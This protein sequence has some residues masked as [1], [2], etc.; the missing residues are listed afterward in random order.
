MV[1]GEGTLKGSRGGSLKHQESPPKATLKYKKYNGDA[2]PTQLHTK[3]LPSQQVAELAQ[4]ARNVEGWRPRPKIIEFFNITDFSHHVDCKVPVDEPIFQPFPPEVTFHNYEP[5]QIYEATLYLRNNDYGEE[6]SDDEEAIL[7]SGAAQLARRL[8]NAQRDA[9]L[10]EHLF[11]DRNFAVSPADGTIWPRSEVEVVVT[12]SP[13]YAREYEVVAYVDLAG[14]SER[15]PVVFKGRGL[16]PAAVFSYDVLDLGDTWVNTLHQYEVWLQNRGKIDVD[17]RLVPPGSAFGTRFSFEPPSG[18]LSGGQMEVIKVKLLSDLL[19]SFDETFSWQI[20]GSSAPLSL[21]FKGRV[22]APSFEVDVEG[23]DFGVCS[24]GFRY[25]KELTLSNT[26]EIPLRFA[27]RVP[28]DTEE[29]RE[30]QILPAKGTIL[31]HGR[32]KV[33][34]EFVSKTVQ[35]YNTELIMDIPGV[36]ERQLALPLVGECA[37]PKLSLFSRNMEFGECSLRF[38][39][40]QLNYD[41]P[42]Y[43]ELK[44]E[45]A[46]ANRG[47]GKKFD[48]SLLPPEQQPVFSIAP[49]KVQLGPKEAA[50]FTVT[51]NALSPVEVREALSCSGTFGNSNK[52]AKK[53]FDTVMRADVAT[54]LLHFSERL[55]HFRYTYRK[56]SAVEAQTR[57]LTIRNISPLPLVFALR[58]TPPFTVDRTTWS[59]DL[60]ESGTVNVT[61]DPNFKDDLQSLQTRTKLQIVYADNPQRD[62]VDLHGDIDFPNL[63]FETTTV[64]FGSVL[65]DTTR[66]VPVRVVN[67]SNVDVVYSWAWD[68]G[69]VQEET[70]SIAS[71]SLRQGRPKPP[72][73]QLFDVMPIRGVLRPGEAEV[74]TFSF[75]AYP[76]VKASCAA[77]CQVEGGPAYTVAISGESNNIKYSVEPQ[78]MDFGIQLYDRTVEREMTL[79]NSG[80]V[81]FTFAFNMS[82]LSRPGIVE[83]TPL[84]GTI[85]PLSKETIKLKVCPGIPEKLVETLLVEIAHFEPVQVQVLVEGTYAAVSL[86]LPRQSDEDFLSC[87]EAARAK[88]INSALSQIPPDDPAKP[89]D[90]AL[91][92]ASG[93][94]GSASA[95][96]LRTGARR[97]AA[98]AAA[99][100]RPDTGGTDATGGAV[101]ESPSPARTITTGRSATARSAPGTGAHRTQSAHSLSG[102]LGLSQLPVEKKVE[103]EAERLRLIHLLL[104]RETERRRHTEH[105]AGLAAAL[106]AGAAAAG[107][108]GPAATLLRQSS[109]HMSPSAS[110]AGGGGDKPRRGA[111]SVAPSRGALTRHMSTVTA[112]TVA[113]R[114][115]D[116]D[117]KRAVARPAGGA[118]S[119]LPSLSVAHYVLDFGYVVKGLTRTRKFKLTNTSSQ[120]VT[121]RF[122]K[123]LLEQAGFKVDP[124]VVSRLPGAPDFASAEVSVTLQAGKASVQPGPVELVYP[125]TI[126]G[127]PPVLL[128]L[129]AHVQVP[130]LKLST[131]FSSPEVGK[132]TDT[133]AFD[134]LGGE[135]LNT[136]VVTGT[137]DYPH[138]STD[139]RNVFYKKV[140][141]RP[142]TPLIRGQYIISKGVF[143]FGP[144]LH[145]KDATGYLEGAHPDNTA[146]IRITNNGLFDNHVEFSLKSQEQKLA[147]EAA[148]GGKGA[149][150]A[151]AKKAEPKKADA[152]KKG[153]KGAAA[154]VLPPA[155]VLDS[156]F[157]LSPAVLDLKVDETQ[158]LCVYGFPMADG[159]VE[160]VII[161]RLRDYKVSCQVLNGPKYTLLLSGVGH[162]PRLDLSWFNHDFGLQPLWQPGMAPAVKALRLRNDDTQPIAVDCGPLVLQPGESREWVVTFKP[163]GAS[164]ARLSLP[165]EINGLYTVH[166]EAKGEGSPLRVEVANPAQRAVNFG[167]VSAG[168]SATRVVSV[169]NRGR[170]PATLSL[171]PS[172]Q[173]LARCSL[174][175][176]PAPGTE[177]VLRPRESAD[178]T[179]F[180]RPPA[181]MRPFTEELLVNLCGVPTPL[182]TLTGACLGTELRLASDSLPFGPVVLGSRAVKRL[183]L[184]N[185]GDVGTKFAWD[186]RALG[187]HFA[188]FPSDGFLAPGQDVKLDVTFQPTEVNPDVRVDKVKLRV[189]GGEEAVLTLTGACIATTA[190]PEA[191]TLSC[192][193][194]ASASQSVT[195]SNTSSTPWSLRP[196][197]QHDFFSG[198]E[199]LSVPANSKATYPITFKP[200]AMSTPEQPHEGSVF[201]PIPDGTGLLYRLVGRA[202]APVPE[203]KVERAV[204]AKTAHVE[205]L[206]CHNWLHKPQRFHVVVERKGGDKSAQISAPEYVDVP[207]LSSKEVKLSVYCYTAAAVNATVTFKNEASG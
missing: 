89:G 121:F 55:L 179:F 204:Q 193:V 23:L 110:Q 27:W 126:K 80:K 93:P 173:L 197:L 144:L 114:A 155:L 1:A 141:A 198:P 65:L 113:T 84:S 37:V 75:F 64:D 112:V 94:P 29:P 132:F 205:V 167:P 12:F 14:R 82:R 199:S 146:R 73:T 115:G 185:T 70:S 129:R 138:I 100:A 26:S 33:N 116:D 117:S 203:G 19:G 140:K 162:K 196:V 135:R 45:Y 92:P 107:Q 95:S 184:E 102:G 154:E 123:S 194:R 139:Y 61:F 182:A 127:S 16:G 187:P 53:V 31:P 58:P 86:N 78:L 22:C 177:L 96:P 105:A 63:A 188:I 25:T 164:A 159:L 28:T 103:V 190:Q 160:D 79:V 41:H 152:G 149:K 163:R 17:F 42:S 46:K 143:E 175:V 10:E 68:K 125:I 128:T 67:S 120:Q 119:G 6:S 85:A 50:V 34:V 5:F 134:V 147:E 180:F 74:M 169:V 62:A 38:P 69:S 49:D 183:Q 178:L 48:L 157:V 189:E 108:P 66:R 40:K 200:L 88:Y 43:E 47:S 57:P 137:C 206:K 166:V 186:T 172:A 130:D 148:S 106:E 124:E 9:L 156:V 111:A 109:G 142:Q 87:L 118:H 35:R 201:F 7:A 30:F 60:E 171:A 191:V 13:D 59:L 24:Y 98:A 131:E 97:S 21:Q 71:L 51:G 133:L 56:G 72:P 145:T 136:L 91:S 168:G 15:L 165:L 104:E 52:G 36:A 44:R 39:Y 122:D 83:A 207:A 90:A 170:T 150:K 202:E 4:P 81:P 174:D 161:A 99:A 181:R 11:A 20:K 176:I 153:G 151:D 192:N 158:E 32:V 8:Q 2:D 3:K 18:R 77:V 76:G 195:I 101:L 54:P